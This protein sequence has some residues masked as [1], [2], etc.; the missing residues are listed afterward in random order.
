MGYTVNNPFEQKINSMTKK[1]KKY[2]TLAGML[3]AAVLSTPS[4]G[5]YE[6][7]QPIPGLKASAGTN[8]GTADTFSA[9]VVAKL[10]F[11]GS[12]TDEKGHAFTPNNVS[13][14]ATAKSGTGSASFSG[15]GALVASGADLALEDKDFTVEA[16]INPASV[17]HVGVYSSAL[18]FGNQLSIRVYSGKLNVFTDTAGS[19]DIYYL[20]SQDIPLNVWTHV[21][22][23]RQGNQFRSYVNGQLDGAQTM[24][25]VILTS[26]YAAIGTERAYYFQ[27]LIDGVKVTKGIARYTG[28]FTPN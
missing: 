14:S 18:G 7:H 19:D 6:F 10:E 28:N 21:A 8:T 1:L 17:S 9:S 13:L 3:F 27:G 15:S 25:G 5:G 11:D 26:P 23:V 12:F 2:A 20:G 24:P 4:F 22:V 16:W